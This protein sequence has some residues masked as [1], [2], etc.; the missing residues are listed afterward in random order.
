MVSLPSA[1]C[2]IGTLDALNWTICGGVCPGGMR[3]MMVC[4]VAVTS[5]NAWSIRTLGWK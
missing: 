3:R 4:E 2:R 1:I 5:A